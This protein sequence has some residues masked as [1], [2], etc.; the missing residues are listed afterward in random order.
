[1]G[2]ENSKKSGEIGEKIAEEL[3]NLIGWKT[4]DRG[5]NVQCK[6]NN[7]HS[8]QEGKKR[9][10]HGID[11]YFNYKC[12]LSDRVQENVIISVKNR[13]S[14]PSSERT[15]R[16]KTKGF[17]RD[18]SQAI[19]CFVK[20]EKYSENKMDG[21]KQI[22]NVGVLFWINSDEDKN[23]EIIKDIADMQITA[24][25][26]KFPMYVVDNK[27][28]NFLFQ[29][30]EYSKKFFDNEQVKFLYPNTGYNNS[31]YEKKP[32]GEVLPVQYINSHIIPFKVENRN[33]L[34]ITSIDRFNKEELPKLIAL[35]QDLTNSWGDKIILAYPDYD[36][37]KHKEDVTWA[38]RK[39]QDN[40]FTERIEIASYGQDFRNLK[41]V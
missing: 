6:K 4:L 21:L 19:E 23:D 13:M 18:L 36:S 8:N 40:K 25:D 35:T 20:S 38:K 41:E 29:S 30:I 3:F 9:T 39:F 22:E 26:I 31:N 17:L 11:F 37:S 33:M 1:M 2:G 27:I 15:K 28:A 12:P 24:N 34:I 32:C 14:Y 10:V 7:E 16:T 5:F